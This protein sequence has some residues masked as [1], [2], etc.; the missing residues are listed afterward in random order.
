[1]VSATIDHIVAITIFITAMMLFVSLF[2][3]TAQTAIAY[4]EHRSLATKC[5]DLLDNMLL[6]P[7]SPG[8]WGQRNLDPI[9]FGLQDPEFT[10]YQISPFSQMRL[11]PSNGAPV[12]YDKTNIYYSNLTIGL[13]NSLLVPYSQRLNYSLALKLLGINNT[14]GFQLTL[15]PTV[16]IKIAKVE[17]ENLTFSL[18]VHG[19]GFPLVRASINY[20]IM[21]V[22]LATNE[23]EYPSYGLQYGN[24]TADD[25]GSATVITN[26]PD[27]NQ[28]YAFIAY[29]HL[30]GVIGVGYHERVS[31]P[32]Q[33]VV[34]MVQDFGEPSVLQ[35]TT[36][37]STP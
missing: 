9:G 30:G 7:G 14:H 12:R 21:S 10:Q 29:A 31:E 6:N 26:V 1:M 36:T 8:D 4:Q 5:S 15:T 22:S 28:S 17:A 25:Q 11:A 3:Q 27:A 19:S 37:T 2:S 24:A 34:P 35:L 33:Y 20:C 16:T 18:G 13:G 32:G 23:A